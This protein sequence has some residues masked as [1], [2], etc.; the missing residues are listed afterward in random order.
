MRFSYDITIPADTPESDPV[1]SILRL[2]RGMIKSIGVRFRIGCNNQVFVA[3]YDALYP[4]VPAAGSTGLYG[5]DRIFEIPLEFDLLKY[6]YE[7]IFFGWSDG[8]RYPHTISVWFDLIPQPPADTPI[9]LNAFI[10][11]L[12]KEVNK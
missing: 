5:N 3:I 9:D 11:S 12:N 8:T 6:P 1:K 7:V 2:D 4:I 10:E